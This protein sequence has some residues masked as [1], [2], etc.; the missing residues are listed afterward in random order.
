MLFSVPYPASES[1]ARSAENNLAYREALRDRGQ[2]LIDPDH[3]EIAR[4]INA[5]S[6]NHCPCCGFPLHQRERLAWR[7]VDGVYVVTHS[8]C[9]P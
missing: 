3:L 1:L 5:G 8:G 9:A 4:A 6:A 7:K 2:L